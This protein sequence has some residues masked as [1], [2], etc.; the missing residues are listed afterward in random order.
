MALVVKQAQKQ[1]FEGKCQDLTHC[2]LF[3][4]MGERLFL[5]PVLYLCLAKD[6]VEEQAYYINSSCKQEDISPAKL[7][8][9]EAGNSLLVTVA[10]FLYKVLCLDAPSL[11]S[12][13][14]PRLP[15]CSWNILQHI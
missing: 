5:S 12:P 15:S 10:Y 9:L 6:E 7:W 11:N 8:I 2:S 13:L 4:E 14:S 1:I 3:S